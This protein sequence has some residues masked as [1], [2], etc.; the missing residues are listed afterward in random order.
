MRI[1]ANAGHDPRPPFPPAPSARGHGPERNSPAH[2][3]VEPRGAEDFRACV[4]SHSVAI[5]TWQPQEYAVLEAIRGCGLE[6]QV[7]FNTGAV[8]V[9]PAGINEASDLKA[10]LREMNISVR[11]Y[12]QGEGQGRESRRRLQ[13]VAA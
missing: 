7:I 2:P 6:L 1:P 13:T 8:I 11:K 3:H 5:T 4:I 9:L 10:A 12:A